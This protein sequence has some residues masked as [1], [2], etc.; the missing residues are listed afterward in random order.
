MEPSL[1]Q[2]IG[3]L[4][5]AI[6]IGLALDWAIYVGLLDSLIHLG[7]VRDSARWSRTM[8]PRTIFTVAAAALT[9]A[10]M[11]GA[12]PDWLIIVAGVVFAAGQ[13]HAIARVLTDQGPR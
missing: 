1:L 11:T 2:F 10:G 13:F 6:L 9:V 7:E 3:Y 5:A 4:V 8:L 12:G